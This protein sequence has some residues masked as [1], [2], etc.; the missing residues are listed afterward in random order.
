MNDSL[1]EKILIESAALSAS[2]R[3]ILSL[4]L[5]R[6]TD[7]DPGLPNPLPGS[8][9]PVEPEQPLASAQTLLGGE[10]E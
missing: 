2:E 3:E 7:S 5:Q 6:M 9:P 8:P 10:G 4:R 1:L